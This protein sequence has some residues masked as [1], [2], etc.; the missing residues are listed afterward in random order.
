M[1][2]TDESRLDTLAVNTGK[3]VERLLE[4]CSLPLAIACIRDALSVAYAA[5]LA[6]GQKAEH[7]AMLLNVPKVRRKLNVGNT[8]EPQ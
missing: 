2:K 7:D 5:G 1:S 6:A 3:T 8:G 4:E